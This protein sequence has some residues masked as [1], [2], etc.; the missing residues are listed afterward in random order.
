MTM[1]TIS[2][3]DLKAG[4]SAALRAVRRGG[5][6]LITDRGR[7]VARIVPVQAAPGDVEPLVEAGLIRTGPRRLPRGFL[8][9]RRPDDPTGS[10]R[11]AVM[12]ER[13]AGH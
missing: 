6:V 8:D 1:K 12:D 9:R 3:S 7:P 4:L 13:E 2:I 10:L 11:Q 5:A